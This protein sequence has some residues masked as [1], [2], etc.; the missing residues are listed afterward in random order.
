MF[1]LKGY[2]DRCLLQLGNIIYDNEHRIFLIVG[3]YMQVG[4]LWEGYLS[5]ELFFATLHLGAFSQVLAWL[6]GVHQFHVGF[7]NCRIENQS[8]FCQSSGVILF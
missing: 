8:L 7:F 2:L 6:V 5:S 1:P 3:K 4:M